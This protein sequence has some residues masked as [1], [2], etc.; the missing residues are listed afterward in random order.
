MKRKR[1]IICALAAVVLFAAGV[2]LHRGN[3][4]LTVSEYTLSLPA[5]PAAFD[6]LRVVQIS[7]LHDA[8]FGE[9]QSE[10]AAQLAAL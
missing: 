8:C 7:D 4:R 9:G 6:G 3:T 2:L 10:L 5:L 1:L